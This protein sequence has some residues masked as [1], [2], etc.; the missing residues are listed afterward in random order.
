MERLRHAGTV[1]SAEIFTFFAEVSG[2]VCIFA[3][4]EQGKYWGTIR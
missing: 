2:L 3:F 4:C 1:E